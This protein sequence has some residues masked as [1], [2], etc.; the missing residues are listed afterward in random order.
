MSSIEQRPA[1]DL[2]LIVNVNGRW[3]EV[4]RG[5]ATIK[6]VVLGDWN[7]DHR[8]IDASRVACVYAYYQKR[9]VAAFAVADPNVVPGYSEPRV[10]F[11]TGHR[12][13]HVEGQTSPH[14]WQRG[15]MHPV[16]AMA[17]DEL[18]EV[19]R[20]TDA[21]AQEIELGGY[22]LRVHHDG[23]ATVLAPAGRTIS[24]R[25]LPETD[26]VGAVNKTSATFD[27]TTQLRGARAET[28]H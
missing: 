5:E 23:D 18:P 24:I 13:R 9:I 20:G 21:T 7:L 3:P 16:F 1:R 8:R 22:L 19:L 28:Q 14:I 15:E 11:R 6:D 2:L 17:L 26:S 12:L 27:L 10:R 4:S 25:S